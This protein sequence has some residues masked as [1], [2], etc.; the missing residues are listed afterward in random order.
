MLG[1]DER[2]VGRFMCANFAMSD[3]FYDGN[4]LG[5]FKSVQMLMNSVLVSPYC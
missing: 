1:V 2:D 3:E 5:T 4:V